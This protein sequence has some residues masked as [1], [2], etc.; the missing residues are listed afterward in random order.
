M[1]L[2]LRRVLVN[3]H[4]LPLTPITPEAEP[5]GAAQPLQDADDARCWAHPNAG[6]TGCFSLLHRMRRPGQHLAAS[7]ERCALVCKLSACVCVH[8]HMPTAPLH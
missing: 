8:V 4:P 2:A 7:L 1:S 6:H 3:F 5:G